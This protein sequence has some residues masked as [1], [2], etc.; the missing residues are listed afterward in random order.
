M[1]TLSYKT[2]N[3]NKLTA[4]KEWVVVDATDQVLG[5]MC[6]KVAKMLRGKYKPE[7][8]PADSSFVPPA[9]EPHRVKRAPSPSAPRRAQTVQHGSR[10]TSADGGARRGVAD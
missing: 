9:S 10:A 2:T 8:T 7:F 6:T 3:V 4:K 5:R 1:D